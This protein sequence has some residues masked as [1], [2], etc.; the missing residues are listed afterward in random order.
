VNWLRGFRGWQAN[1]GAPSTANQE[2]AL[3][4]TTN[5]ALGALIEMN[6]QSEMETAVIGHAFSKRIS[7]PSVYPAMS[8]EGKKLNIST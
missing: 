4:R 2:E 8:L 3:V 1:F 6:F 5:Q 7:A